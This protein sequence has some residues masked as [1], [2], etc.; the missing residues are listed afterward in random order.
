MPIL[1]QNI[2]DQMRFALDAE[3]ADHYRDDLDIIPA[4]NAAQ[5]W[6][7]SVINS[8]I[9]EK[10]YGEEIFQDLSTARVFRTSV[11]SRISLDSFPD[12]VWTITGIYPLPETKSTGQAA[13]P[14]VT[15]IESVWRNDLYHVDAQF[16]AK[17]LTT[18]EWT[19]NR[20]NPFE[21]GFDGVAVC[22]DVK[23][24]AYLA[25]HDYEPDGVGN[26]IRE[27]EI[28]PAVSKDLVTVF[29]I[30][31]PNDIDDL[32][33]NIEFPESVFQLIFN[34]ALA[35][36]AYKQGDQTTLFAV[37]QNDINNLMAAIS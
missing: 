9:G 31:R 5:K 19:F 15:D 28:R 29:Y 10:K 25:P 20:K 1:A 30:R 32:S 6:I 36:I 23:Q 37:S 16:H 27:I 11:D 7:V 26:I 35:Y 34:K 13:P 22:D 2:A 14:A 17:R 3:G 24:Y 33:D 21:A 8:A 18:E 4:I 12:D